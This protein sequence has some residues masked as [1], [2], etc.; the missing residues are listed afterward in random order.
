MKLR[1][2]RNFREKAAFRDALVRKLIALHFLRVTLNEAEMSLI[3][4]V[5]L[6]EKN[7]Q[8]FVVLWILGVWWCFQ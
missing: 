4:A 1:M 7:S 5:A 3:S 6:V 8:E 2:F